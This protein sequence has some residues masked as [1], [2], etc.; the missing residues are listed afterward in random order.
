VYGNAGLSFTSVFLG[1]WQTPPGTA[2]APAP[3][4]SRHSACAHLDTSFPICQ[5]MKE[6]GILKRIQKMPTSTTCLSRS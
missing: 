6:H 1:P 2:T 3:P 5:P 4:S